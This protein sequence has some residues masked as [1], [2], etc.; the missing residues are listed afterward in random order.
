[1]KTQKTIK[2]IKRAQKEAEAMRLRNG[3]AFGVPQSVA[4]RYIQGYKGRML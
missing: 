2:L 1:M 4:E 3:Q